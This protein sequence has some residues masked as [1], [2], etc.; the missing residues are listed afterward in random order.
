MQMR[1]NPFSPQRRKSR[2]A[3]LDFEVGPGVPSPTRPGQR[4]SAPLQQAGRGRAAPLR[5]Q[6]PPPSRP[7]ENHAH[8]EAAPGHVPGPEPEAAARGEGQGRAGPGQQ[9]PEWAGPWGAGRGGGARRGGGAAPGEPFSPPSSFIRFFL[10]PFL[11]N[12]LTWPMLDPGGQGN[13][14]G[15]PGQ[16]G[17]RL[18]WRTVR[19]PPTECHGRGSG[20][21]QLPPT[22]GHPSCRPHSGRCSAPGSPPFPASPLSEAP[23]PLF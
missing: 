7:A 5:A 20:A 1:T 22:A 3:E 16:G 9:G 8:A 21:G 13:P 10:P 2:Y 11:E 15:L 18:D 23:S 17:G 4:G 14:T 19:P 12:D 6:P